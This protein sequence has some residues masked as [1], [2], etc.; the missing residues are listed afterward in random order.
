MQVASPFFKI[1]VIDAHFRVAGKDANAR[2]E[3]K[4]LAR[5]KLQISDDT[6]INLG[7]LTGERGGLGQKSP[8]F[9]FKCQ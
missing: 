7:F 2:E 3:L 6:L 9:K 5:G 4:H 1:G 8:I